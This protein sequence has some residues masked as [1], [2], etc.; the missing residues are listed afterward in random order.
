MKKSTKV[1]KLPITLFRLKWPNYGLIDWCKLKH[2][3]DSWSNSDM[4]V[5]VSS[6]QSLFLQS[7]VIPSIVLDK[8][9]WCDCFPMLLG[10]SFLLVFFAS[11]KAGGDAK[12]S[13]VWSQTMMP[14]TFEE[15]V[16]FIKSVWIIKCDDA[17]QPDNSFHSQIPWSVT[18]QRSFPEHAC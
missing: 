10:K 11:L 3:S 1:D 6:H 14:Q 12:T 13:S 16:N 5:R 15:K 17:F 8:N 7:F 18:S 2:I 9:S 4:E